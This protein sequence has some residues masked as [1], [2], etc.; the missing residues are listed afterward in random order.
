[1]SATLFA[2]TDQSQTQV[3]NDGFIYAEIVGTSGFLTTKVTV[4]IDFGQKKSFWNNNTVLKDEKGNAIKFNSMVDAM[5]FMGG[6]GWDFAQAYAI[7][8]GNQNV[9]HFL[10]KKKASKEELQKMMSLV[11]T[12]EN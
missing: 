11:K 12:P 8:S 6:L 3:P 4:Q 9:Y 2:Q 1:M 7:T 10:L 5:N